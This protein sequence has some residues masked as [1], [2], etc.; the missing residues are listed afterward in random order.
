MS[1]DALKCPLCGGTIK[2]VSGDTPMI[3]C[4]KNIFSAG[5][6]KGCTFFM[7]LS[8]K[9]LGGYVFTRDEIGMML[10][11][12]TVEIDGIKAEYDKN[13]KFNPNLIFPPLEDF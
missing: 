12:E 11:G 10:R 2:K 7:S 3:K 8:P 4:E 9:P 13:A 5:V 1:Q 6:Q